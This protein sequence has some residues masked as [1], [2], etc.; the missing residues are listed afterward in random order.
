MSVIG[1]E[2]EGILLERLPLTRGTLSSQ[3]LTGVDLSCP[4]S[5][6]LSILCL[7]RME[8]THS[9][10]LLFQH[11]P[12]DPRI[13]KCHLVIAHRLKLGLWWMLKTPLS[14]VSN[15]RL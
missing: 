9:P 7:E 10:V 4:N 13:T 3:V 1:V 6:I 12:E 14:M 5:F 15:T 2:S 11:W 8:Q